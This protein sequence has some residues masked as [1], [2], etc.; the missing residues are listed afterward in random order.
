MSGSKFTFSTQA[1]A[2]LSLINGK[3]YSKMSLNERYKWAEFYKCK[4]DVEWYTPVYKKLVVMAKA[5]MGFWV[6]IILNWD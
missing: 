2:P 3:D 1:T 4:L 6:L 5:R